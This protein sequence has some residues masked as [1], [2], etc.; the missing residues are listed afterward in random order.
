MCDYIVETRGDS[1]YISIA[2]EEII[3][4]ISKEQIEAFQIVSADPEMVAI[5]LAIVEFARNQQK[6]NNYQME[7]VY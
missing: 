1:Y 5:I 4:E 2:G 3:V 7:F 6:T